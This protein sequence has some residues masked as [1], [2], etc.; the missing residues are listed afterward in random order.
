MRNLQTERC[1]KAIETYHA[2]EARHPGGVDR[3]KQR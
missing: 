2:F 1:G 3:R